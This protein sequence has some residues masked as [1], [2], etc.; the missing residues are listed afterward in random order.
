MARRFPL[1]LRRDIRRG[2]REYRPVGEL[3]DG[4]QAVVFALE[5]RIHE[6]KQVGELRSL[7]SLFAYFSEFSLAINHCRKERPQLFDRNSLTGT[8]GIG[9]LQVHD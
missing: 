3:G 6:L 8:I 7:A 1:L 9:D 4:G 2:D 5:F